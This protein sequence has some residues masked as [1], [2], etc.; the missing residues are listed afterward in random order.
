MESSNLVHSSKKE[1]RRVSRTKR[2][3]NFAFLQLLKQKDISKITIKELCNLA[4]INRK[5][6]YTYFNS[7][8]NVLSEIENEMINEF[9]NRNLQLKAEKK[10]LTVQ[11]IFFCI[12]DLMSSNAEFIHQLVQV[13]ALE[14]L[15]KKV[16]QT[17]KNAVAETI[18]LKH[19]DS[20]DIFNLSMEYAISGAISMYI[21]WFS[22]D[23]KIPLKMLSDLTFDLV[24]PNINFALNYFDKKD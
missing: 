20:K 6:F 15:E 13:D 22:T 9:Q 12:G 4:D 23:S 21:E 3:I 16:K 2:N 5:T 17:I 10:T 1:D 19:G 8:D 11:D 24:K 7:V 14:S 18:K